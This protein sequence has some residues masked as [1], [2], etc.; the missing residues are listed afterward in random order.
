[1]SLAVTGALT[2]SREC[3][4]KSCLTKE[5]S[6]AH[7]PEM[8]GIVMAKASVSR[9]TKTLKAPHELMR[10]HSIV[11]VRLGIGVFHTERRLERRM[12]E[13]NQ[14]VLMAVDLP[15]GSKARI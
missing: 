12:L 15:L 6:I 4:Y 14:D 7:I 9:T 3:F 11:P 10:T 13:H 2:F 5:F 1:M 8:T